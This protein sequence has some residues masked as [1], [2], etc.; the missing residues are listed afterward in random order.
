MVN[1]V[2]YLE[3]AEPIKQLKREGCPDEAL[4]LC[5]QSVQVAEN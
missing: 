3:T 1:G 2:H 4:A 5:M